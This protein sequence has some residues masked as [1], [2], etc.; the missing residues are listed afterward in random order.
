MDEPTIRRGTL[1]PFALRRLGEMLCG[2]YQ[3]PATLPSRVYDLAMRLDRRDGPM[4]YIVHPDEQGPIPASKE[5]DYRRQAVEAMRLAQHASS[6]SVRTRLVN[7]AEAWIKLAERA[8]KAS[9]S[10]R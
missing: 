8:R 2:R 5:S 3:L 1:S 10:F 7:L 9:R 4:K 6:P